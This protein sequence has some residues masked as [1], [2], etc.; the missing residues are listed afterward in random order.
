MADYRSKYWF[1][2]SK[3]KRCKEEEGGK[4]NLVCILNFFVFLS[5][6]FM[7]N[8]QIHCYW[9]DND[10]FLCICYI[11]PFCLWQK[12]QMRSRAHT[13]KK[14]ECKKEIPANKSSK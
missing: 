4:R 12:C 6:S 2:L 5:C 10:S 8:L 13:L 3:E 9:H 11:D 7:L 1:H 14:F